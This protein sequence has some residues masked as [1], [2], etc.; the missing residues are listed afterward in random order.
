MSNWK[1]SKEKIELFTH[2]NADTLQIGKVGSY[3]VVVQK[4]MYNDGDF[5]VFAPEK[6]ILSG[7]L[8]QEYHTYLA[9]VAQNRVKEVRLRGE[10]SA[11]IIIPQELL[12]FDLSSV[13]E[14]EDIS[15]RLGITKY[16]PPIP[17]ELEGKV[18]SFEMPSIGHH[19]CEQYA[20][21]VK[22]LVEGERI[23]VS[24][25]LH[26]SMFTL[27]YN[28]EQDKILIS[29]KNLL[30]Q[31]LMFEGYEN[32][33]YT[34]AAENDKIIEK[35]K[36]NYSSGTVQ[37]FGEVLPVQGGYGYGFEKPGIKVFDIRVDGQIIPYDM[38]PEDFK[39]LWVPIL[40]DGSLNMI[41]NEV[42]LHEDPET[43]EKIT[44]K[45]QFLPESI[46][47]LCEGMETVSGRSI[48]IREGVVLRPY[49]DRYAPDGTKLRLKIINPKYAK[50]STGEEIN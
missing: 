33:S 16:E 44:R 42:L 5:V 1:V 2:T 19:D 27:A 40:F 39:S 47:K 30:K 36:A 15:L 35:I 37:I 23:V 31:G 49:I 28:F 14:G 41:H 7:K 3:Q 24:E 8:K 11:G 9:G 25:K 46:I 45:E 38:V 26:G 21:Y 43:G 12:D 6:S 17:S 18:I 13:E 10:V 34:R 32:N 50:K 20:V 4:G 22:Q 48:H 29:S